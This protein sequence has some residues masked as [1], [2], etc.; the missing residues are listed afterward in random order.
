[1]EVTR[2]T[3]EVCF[4]CHRDLLVPGLPLFLLLTEVIY[5][6]GSLLIEE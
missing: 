1:M 4:P 5:E 3:Y 2:P 6:K